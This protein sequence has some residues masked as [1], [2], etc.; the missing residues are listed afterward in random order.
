ME[1]KKELTYLAGDGL[2]KGN[3]IL[4]NM[5]RT[6]LKESGIDVYNPWDQK[7]INDKSNKPT[8]E[9]I[10]RKDTD[11]ILKAKNI[12]FEADDNSVGTT[13]EVGQTW[14]IN[15]MWGRIADVLM[16]NG[17]GD[18]RK[19]F[20]DLLD[21]IPV[22]K[23]YWQITDVRHTDIPE[24]GARRSHS[25]NQYLHGCLLDMAGENREFDDIVEEIK[26]E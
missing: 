8:A 19:A 16:K 13:T 15:Y 25:L 1:N 10:F 9:M 23:V 5:E 3:Q 4:R 12:I 21:E 26:S 14:G 24:V 18:L 17:D 6:Q 22:K 7:D 11:A 20:H 2:K